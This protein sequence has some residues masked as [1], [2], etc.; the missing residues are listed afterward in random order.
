MGDAQLSAETFLSG[1]LAFVTALVSIA[2]MMS[3]LRRASF[4][5][6]GVYRLLLGSFLLAIAYGW[7]G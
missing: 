5:V 4:T 1:G 7:I 2:L 6:F 3:W